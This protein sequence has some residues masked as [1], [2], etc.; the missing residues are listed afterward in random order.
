[1]L[2]Y[3]RCETVFVLYFPLIL[4][5]IS[6]VDLRVVQLFSL[7]AYLYQLARLLSRHARLALALAILKLQRL[8]AVI[9]VLN[10]TKAD[11][12]D[13]VASLHVITRVYD[14]QIT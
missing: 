4:Q 12:L 3:L 1:M 5:T 6:Q 9:F 11:F 14:S 13:F 2:L 7:D 8:S 10:L